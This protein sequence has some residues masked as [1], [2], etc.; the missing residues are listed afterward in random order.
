MSKKTVKRKKEKR[1]SASRMPFVFLFTTAALFL[2]FVFRVLALPEMQTDIASGK[3]IISLLAC[4]LLTY[5]ISH[6]AYRRLFQSSMGFNQTDKIITAIGAAAIVILAGLSFQKTLAPN[7]DNAEY[8]ISAKS[9]V[10]RGGAYRLYTRNETYNSLAALG[11]P[12]MLSPVYALWGLDIVKMKVLI[13]LLYLGIFPALFLLF[14]CFYNQRLSVIL[15]LLGWCSPY[16]IASSSSIM[17][18]T[19]FLLFSILGLHAIHRF[20]HQESWSWKWF[21]WMMFTVIMTFLVRAIGIGLVGVLLL[22]LALQVPWKSL[23]KERK[24]SPFWSHHAFRKLMILSVPLIL[25]GVLLQLWQ[26]SQGISQ[27]AIFFNKDLFRHVGDNFF[28]ARMVIGQMLYSEEIFRWF[29]FDNES[30]LPRHNVLSILVSVILVMGL[31]RGL[32]QKNLI[33]WYTLVTMLLVL[34]GSLTPQEMVTMRYNMVLLPA[35]IVLFYEGLIWIL[36]LL[37]RQKPSLALKTLGNLT[38]SILLIQLLFSSMAGNIYSIGRAERGYGDAYADFIQAAEWCKDNLPDD[39]FVAS[40][41]PRIFYVFSGKKGIRLAGGRA[42][43]SAEY[44]EN[45]LAFFKEMKVTHLILDQASGRTQEAIF[46][47][48]DNNTDKFEMLHVPKPH[49]T[50]GIVQVNSY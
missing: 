25:G 41:K 46:P 16:V 32:L 8:I 29:A 14:R 26:Q 4:L 12:A 40:M 37:D 23:L 39:V 21:V 5:S 30:Q 43:Y 50:C 1:V 6:L 3:R 38:I 31:I 15:A 13:F 48:V 24:W 22:Y 45:R 28:S 49:G 18:E 34:F 17:T 47:I 11:L 10:E 35:F 27:A 19:P 2:I 42:E 7:G 33:A 20:V 44:E 36:E 9:L